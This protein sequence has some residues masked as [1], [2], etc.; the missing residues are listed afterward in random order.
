MALN[1]GLLDRKQRCPTLTYFSQMV[2]MMFYVLKTVW[3]VFLMSPILSIENTWLVIIKPEH[4]QG[5]ENLAK[6]SDLNFRRGYFKCDFGVEAD[7]TTF[8]LNRMRVLF[9]E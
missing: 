7:N 6:T 1:L 9:L 4:T 8:Q 2:N 3:L 5:M